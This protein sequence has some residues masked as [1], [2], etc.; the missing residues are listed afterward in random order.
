ME[1][2]IINSIESHLIAQHINW[3]KCKYRS[4][5]WVS[6]ELGIS[7][8]FRTLRKSRRSRSEYL[9]HRI[10]ENKNWVQLRRLN[11]FS[12]IRVVSNLIEIIVSQKTNWLLNKFENI[13]REVGVNCLS[14]S[15]LTIIAKKSHTNRFMWVLCHHFYYD[16]KS[17][18]LRIDSNTFFIFF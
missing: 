11:L 12:Q 10:N 2:T 7:F 4:F 6:T 13:V 8:W 5:N 3:L 17:L 18:S 16:L 9:E 15:V 1:N 14:F